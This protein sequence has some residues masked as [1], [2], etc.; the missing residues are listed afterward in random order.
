[1]KSDKKIPSN[2]LG[3]EDCQLPSRDGLARAT[4][5]CLSESF[6]VISEV[7]EWEQMEFLF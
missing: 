1:M 6:D 7:A 2:K 5:V 3:Y 4:E